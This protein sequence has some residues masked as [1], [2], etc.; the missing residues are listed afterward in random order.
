MKAI[1]NANAIDGNK[2][3]G[4]PQ[5]NNDNNKEY[6]DRSGIHHFFS[7]VISS[8]AMVCIYDLRGRIPTGTSWDNPAHVPARPRFQECNTIDL[9]SNNLHHNR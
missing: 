2:I 5:S 8:T 4:I 1:R 9:L 3:V 7:Q 6:A